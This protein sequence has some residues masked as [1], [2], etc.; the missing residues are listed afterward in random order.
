MI[1]K[2]NYTFKE[3]NQ[4]ITKSK[5]NPQYYFDGQHIKTL[6]TDNQSTGSIANEKGNELVLTIPDITIVQSNNTIVTSINNGLNVLENI[7]YINNGEIDNQLVNNIL[8]EVSFNQVIIGH[9]NTREGIILFTTDDN[10]M[11]CVWLVDNILNNDYNIRLLYL[12]NLNFSTSNPIQAIFNYE[13]D[14]IQKVYW[15][16][17]N[18]QLRFLNINHSIENGDLED[19]INLNSNS[20]NVTGEY[21][22]SQIFINQITQGGSHTSGMIQYTYNLY[23]LNGSQTTTA[24]LSE[25]IPLDSG[26]GN[27][28]GEVN[29]SV[30]ASPLINIETLDNRYTHIKVYAIKYTSYNQEPQISVIVDEEIDNYNLFSY[31]D[32]GSVLYNISLAEF[33]FLGSNVFVPKHIEIKDSRMFAASITDKN[34]DLDIDT[35]AYSFTEGINNECKLWEQSGNSTAEGYPIGP[36][37]TVPDDFT[38]FEKHDC[39]NPDYNIYKYQSDGVT[40]GGE[41]KF[42]KYELKQKTFSELINQDLRF[43]KF[44][45][46]LEI[47]RI[48]IQFYNTLGQYTAPKWIADIKAPSGN[49]EGNYNTLKVEIKETELNDYLDSLNLSEE[50]RP[51]GYKILRADRTANDRTIFCQGNLTGMMVQTTKDVA[52]FSYWIDG[53]ALDFSNNRRLESL[54]RVKLPLLVNRGFPSGNDYDVYPVKTYKHLRMLN[55][56]DTENRVEIYRDDDT[57]Y[58]RQQTWQYLKMMQ[59]Y[60]PDILFNTG[61]SF[62]NNTRLRVLGAYER[63]SANVWARVR[64]INNGNIIENNFQLNTGNFQ[65]GGNLGM[66]GPGR[67]DDDNVTTSVRYLYIYNKYNNFIKNNVLSYNI[68]KKPEITERGQNTTSYGGDNQF[69]YKNSLEDLLSDKYK[70]TGQSEKDENSIVSANTLGSKCVTIVEGLDNI[71]ENS[72]R[73]LLDL[74]NNTGI[75]E[76]DVLLMAELVAPDY[77]VY[78][79]NIYGGNTYE[80]KTRNSYIE[81]GEYKNINETIIQID[82]PGD[83]FVQDFNFGRL[84][85]SDTERFSSRVHQVSEIMNYPVETSINLLNRNDTSILGWDNKFQPKDEEYHQYNRV[86]S[87]QP[88]LIKNQA[89]SFKLKKSNLFDARVIASKLKIPGETIDSWTDFLENETIDL[90]GKYGPINSLVSYEDQLYTFQDKAI[91]KLSINPRVQV[92]GSDGIDIELGTGNVL[93]EYN[94]LTT[95]SGSINKWG[96][97]STKKGIYYYDALNKS[98]GRIPDLT[99]QFLTD[100]KGLHSFYNN[101]YNYDL[102]KLDNPILKNGVVF[103]FDNYNNDVYFTLHQEDKSFTWC[104]NELKEG[105]IDLKTYK[106]SHYINQG[107]KLLLTNNDNNKLYEQY[108]GEYNKFFDEYQPSYITLMINPES[109]KDCVFNNI[110]Y[111]SELYLNDI[112][113]PD[114]TL[115]H[116]QAYNEY[117]NSGLIPL[118]LGRNL[119][120]RRKF[121][122]WKANIPRDK[123]DRIR[124]PWIF[125]KLELNNENN[126]EMILHDIEVY[127]SVY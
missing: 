112:D 82:S 46:D 39:I 88:N 104:Y 22:L 34:Y 17:G 121:R 68:Y 114:K 122:E 13:N 108:K 94:Y 65:F 33:S 5:H 55:E 66:Y 32:D 125:L 3:V 38:V 21:S 49:L 78:I 80:S 57:D 59:M 41:G 109:N 63:E 20:L 42:I 25:L 53:N 117:Q 60:S 2:S 106:P 31:F 9:A 61:L 100:V 126:Y 52:N 110:S 6:S 87:Q 36:F 127:Y 124:N 116:I 19:L 118:Q 15:V 7:N 103:G 29:E 107:E 35:R 70:R 81:I 84:L 12:R 11:D 77:Y 115:T 47:Y 30:G 111:K 69:R 85:K 98:I 101:N 16:D 102:I 24:P 51:V 45:K 56:G 62:T 40:L 73:S 76:T 10:G 96:N 83:T 90:D 93:Y 105:F 37:L 86:Y 58:K 26:E 23:K 1:K 99:K 97:I 89:E 119:N 54:N 72:R 79:G 91:S 123:R 4:D 50:E 27:G 120:L 8:P 48:S 28:G 74:Y 14:I 71:D 92:Q 95:K 64:N 44:F 67:D 75:N 113:Q 43:N 18:N